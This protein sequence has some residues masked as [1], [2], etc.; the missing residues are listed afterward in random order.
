MVVEEEE[1]NQQGQ[2]AHQFFHYTMLQAEKLPDHQAYL[3][4]RST[5]T[6]FKTKTYLEK[7]RRTSQG[8]KINCNSRAM[9]T[10]VVGDYGTMKEKPR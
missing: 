4:C 10:N 5:L 8:V 3:G 6:A 9:K 2:V 7:L 1:Y